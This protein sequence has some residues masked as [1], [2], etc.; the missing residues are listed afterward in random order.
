MD[1]DDV[2][3]KVEQLSERISSAMKAMTK[4]SFGDSILNPEQAEQF[5]RTVEIA[6]PVLMESRRLNMNESAERD[7][8]RVA[9]NN[10][11]F[12]DPSQSESAKTEEADTFT[13]QLSA[14]E[15]MGII[16][17]EDDALEDNIEQEDFEDTLLDMI[18]DQ[19][20]IDWEE[21]FINGDTTSGDPYLALTDGWAKL[22]ANQVTSSNYDETDPESALQAAFDAVPYKYTSSRQTNRGDWRFYV[23]PMLE[24][25]YR[26]VLRSRGTGLGDEAQTSDNPLTYKGFPVV[27]IGNMPSG[28]LLFTNP[29]NLAYGVR[30]DIRIEEDREPKQ[31]K[32][33][34]VVTARV[35]AHYEDENGAAH[36]T[37]YTG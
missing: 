4:S 7:I 36:V 17:I 8:N 29:D 33:D 3:G 24:D 31:R 14:T 34:F 23:D 2:L 25:N 18:G 15:V 1:N 30:R 11:V 9:F 10:R 16:G 13:N 27:D 21:L 32:T 37:G 19:A 20:G 26:D 35:D 6:T 22:A 12:H 5:I 28:E